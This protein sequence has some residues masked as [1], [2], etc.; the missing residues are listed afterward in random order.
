MSDKPPKILRNLNKGLIQELVVRL[1]LIY[2]LMTD[3]RVSP[4]LK[5]I[6]VGALAYWLIPDPIIGPIDDAT[7]LWLG[8]YLFVEL[9]PPAIV[10]EHLQALRGAIPGEWKDTKPGSPP[11]EEEV[12]DGEFKDVS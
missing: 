3:R 7:I 2:R 9:C 6:P 12:I 1:K 4:F 10:Q 5:I 11:E 8:S